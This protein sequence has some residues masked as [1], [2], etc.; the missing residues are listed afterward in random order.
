M[1]FI[2][3]KFPSLDIILVNWNSGS[4]LESCLE[5]VAG[6]DRH[7]FNLSRIVVVDNA[8]DDG[9]AEDLEK[10]PLPITIIRNEKNR[11]FAAACNQGASDCKSD[12][13]LFLNP[14]TRLFADSLN[15]TISFMERPESAK[16]GICG[17]QLVDEKGEVTR[18]C[19]R[20]PKPLVFF[21]KMFGLDRFLP[22]EFPGHFM[23][24]WDHQED[25]EVDQVMGAF[26]LIRRGV[27]ESLKGF[28]ERFFVYFED[29]DLSL[30][31]HQTGWQ[32]YYLAH[33]KAYHKG[34]GTSE[35]IKALR[36]FYSLRSRILFGFKHFGS[37]SAA[38]LL[39]GTMLIEPFSRLVL[40]TSRRSV[41]EIKETLAG[42][43]LLWR[44]LGSVF[45]AERG[46][47]QP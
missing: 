47:N 26:F 27:F 15:G 11:G 37:V 28:D 43:R 7:G 16:I 39:L 34:A 12:Y 14:D 18:S 4:L 8:S 42:Y 9:S 41:I 2:N 36:L 19:A 40:A 17:I 20:F 46:V 21:S 25:R 35:Q 38:S 22:A 1:A 24:E 3:K 30:R 33:F 29:V 31:A 6:A 32:S 45:Q 44:S 5:S 23:R 13:L 10:L